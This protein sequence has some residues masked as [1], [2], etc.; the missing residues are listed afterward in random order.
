MIQSS[1]PLAI[2]TGASSGIGEA[3]SL[4]L[5]RAGYDLLLVAR[6]EPLLGALSRRITTEIP[7]A[8][9]TPLALDLAQADA[10]ERLFAHAPQADLVVNNAGFARVADA[11]EVE[12]S[13]YDEMIA[14][15][16]ATVTR[17]TLRFARQMAG[18]GG[19]T[20]L[21]I[22]STSGFQ[23]IPYQ[24]VYAA[25]KAYVSSFSEALAFELEGKGV[26]VLV[27]YP[28]PTN[29]AFSDVAGAKDQAKRH[30]R[31]FMSAEAVADLAMEQI[32]TGKT[33]LVAGKLNGIAA[34]LA[35]IGPRRLSRRIA[36]ELF[37]PSR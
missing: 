6:R 29:T 27:L 20:I 4:R 19:G 33:A 30:A 12:P 14:L 23:P 25:T 37:R 31:F 18:R 21:N 35:Q 22:G 7:E 26:N 16:V 5:A 15:N 36:A 2:V 34:A 3:L 32:R 1:R 10:A 9:A 13:V 28:G 11:L 8:K 17:L 24:A